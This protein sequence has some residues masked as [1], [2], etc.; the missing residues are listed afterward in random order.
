MNLRPPP[1]L[2]ISEW[3]DKYRYLSSEASA[4]A[5][6]WNTGRAEFQRE[7]MDC[8]TRPEVENLVIMSSSQIG[9]TEILL[10]IIG[11]FIHLDSAPMLMI[12]PTLQ[13]AGTFSKNRISTMIRDTE[14]LTDKVLPARSR[15]S[16]NTIFA[17]S[18]AGGSLDL[19]GSNSASS[20]SSRPIRILLC[21]EVD[22][23]SV[24]GTTEG[25]IISLGKRRTSNF[26]NRKVAMVS[27]PTTKGSSRIETAYEQSDQ[28]KFYVPCGDCG[29][30]QI[31]EWKNVYWTKGNHHE[32]VYTCNQC[33]SAWD[34]SARLGAIRN[35]SWKAHN[36]FN[37]T[38]GF[39]I[40][41]LYSSWSSLGEIVDLFLA[42]KDLPETLRVFTNTVLAESW[43]ET[44]E[45]ID[46]FA[47][48]ERAEDY[49]DKLPEDVCLLVCGVDTQ[50]DR[51][52]ATVLGLTRK[53]EAYVI[54]H[55][56]IY[57]DIA[58]EEVWDELDK[59][60]LDKYPH[61]T[62]ID[63][64]IQSTCVDSGGHFTNQVYN[65][66]KTRSSRRVHAIK[67][68]GGKDRAMVGRPS[69]SNVGK[70]L[71]YPLGSDTLKDHVY[72]RLKV[73]EGAGSIHFP[74]HLDAEYFAQLTSEER[75]SKLIRGVRRTEWVKKRKRNEAWDCLCY[76]Y[77]AYSLLN[78]N[79][80]V[81]HEKLHRATKPEK[82][83]KS[84]PMRP[85]RR[86]R[87]WMDI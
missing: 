44:G 73:A 57:G 14:V 16:N 71:L 79:L 21:D 2:T 49:G 63:L 77:A 7:I 8:F 17:K 32:A 26:Y 64:S 50:D 27:T 46:D 66:T 35:G 48:A 38:A 65:F 67:G 28:R 78:V 6:K 74:K 83:K 12:H 29:H 36:E 33:G 24:Q 60:L 51:L 31:L 62:G 19:I 1:K 82:E 58:G 34:D 55:H 56:V 13:M 37:N 43:E 39:W 75:V 11:Y 42:S 20:V 18:F 52:E 84:N 45:K 85:M 53:E 86:G 47:L 9:K 61:P 3:A 25:D 69:R 54:D 59:V 87:K 70:V 40:N 5:G 4:E 80:R 15:D 22:R 68:V 23:Y 72:G 10:N 41:G 76:A 81:L 30:S